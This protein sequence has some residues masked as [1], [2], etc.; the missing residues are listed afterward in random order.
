M[1]GAFKRIENLNKSLGKITM[2]KTILIE[3][4]TKHG[5]EQ[6][7]SRVPGLER[8]ICTKKL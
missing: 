6:S 7:I 2:T 4:R 5:V 1:L 3:C 8:Q